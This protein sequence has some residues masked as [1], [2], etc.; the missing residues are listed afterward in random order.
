MREKEERMQRVKGI[1]LMLAVILALLF[2]PQFHV[3]AQSTAGYTKIASVTTGTSYTDSTCPD[4]AT[5][6]YEVTA[7]NTAGESL[8]AGPVGAQIPATGTHTV[9]LTWTAGGG[10][11]TPAGYNV[12]QQKSP[13]PP[14]GLGAAVN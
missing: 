6:V 14:S 11:G 12:Y 9:A 2:W 1:V 5:C 3:G 8:P 13:V 10:G 7:Y 4:G